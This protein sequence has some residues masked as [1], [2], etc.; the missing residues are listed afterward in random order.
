[1]SI[2]SNIFGGGTGTAVVSPG[3]TYTI[4]ANASGGGGG[5]AAQ[6]RQASS[7]EALAELNANP[8]S[9]LTLQE[10]RDLFE[11]R[12]ASGWHYPPD[13]QDGSA[14]WDL[15]IDRMQNAGM[16]ENVRVRGYVFWRLRADC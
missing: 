15:I 2:L 1:M 12:F 4:I 7:E 3:Q 13:L 6:Q 10:C 8:A 11:S 14:L 16:F 9:S 5:V